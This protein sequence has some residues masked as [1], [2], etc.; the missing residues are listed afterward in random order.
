MDIAKLSDNVAKLSTQINEMHLCIRELSETV[1]RQQNGELMARLERVE[2]SLKDQNL[3]LDSL[4]AVDIIPNIVM[5]SGP[6]TVK[7]AGA[8]SK[9][10][11]AEPAVATTAATPATTEKQFT[12]ITEFFKHLWCNSREL[13][14]EKDV[15]TQEEFDK[16]YEENKEKLEKKKKN[17]LVMQKSIA[18]TVWRALDQSKKDI[19]YALKNQNANDVQKKK[20]HDITEEEEE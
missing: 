5:A 14:F 20:S 2:L 4:S 18:F 7:V 10:K 8:K 3:K 9:E 19:V 15:L 13:L 11:D 17:E 6:T 12:N 1:S 16:I